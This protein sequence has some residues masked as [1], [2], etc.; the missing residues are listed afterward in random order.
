[1]SNSETG[2]VTGTVERLERAT[3]KQTQRL[4]GD[5]THTQFVMSDK[6]TLH[7]NRPDS[8]NLVSVAIQVALV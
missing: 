8:G 4:G 1:M 6:E 3:V 5:A 2:V 7:L